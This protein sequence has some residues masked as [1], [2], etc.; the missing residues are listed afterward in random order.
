MKSVTLWASAFFLLASPAVRG[1]NQTLEPEPAGESSTPHED[2]RRTL[3]RFPVNVLL[4]AVGIYHE[5][6][7]VPAVLGTTFTA[8]GSLFD[9]DFA[10]Y[11]ADPDHGFGQAVED[12]AA[13]EVVGLAV[14]GVFTVGRFVDAPRFRAMSYDLLDAFL[15]NWAWT[16]AFKAAVARERPNGE[17]DKSFP[18]GH[19]SNAFALAAVTERHYGWKAG[20][21]AYALASLV[22]LSRP[23][24]NKHYLTDVM[25]GATLGYLVGHTVVRVNGR[26]LDTPGG[27]EVS[28]S[29]VVGPRTRALVL[30]LS[31]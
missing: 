30:T 13:P 3:R 12:V 16:S 19:A 2:G 18:S 15:V 1:D 27:I 7:L 21:P 11:V 29:P 14:A 31:F 23:Q 24:R 8:T 22:A 4:G 9:D 6:N 25:A 26:P 10:A 17:D 5:D 28:L 20:V